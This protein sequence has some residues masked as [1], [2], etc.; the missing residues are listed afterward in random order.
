MQLLY[1]NQLAGEPGVE[2]K[3]IGGRFVKIWTHRLNC[4]LSR[5]FLFVVD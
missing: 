1:C 3:S 4:S 2:W 5:L